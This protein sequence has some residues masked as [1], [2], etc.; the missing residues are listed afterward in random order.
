MLFLL[1]ESKSLNINTSVINRLH[2]ETVE[3][4]PVDIGVDFLASNTING[5][6]F[7]L[8]MVAWLVNIYGV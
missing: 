3:G 8:L 5:E 2:S 1:L 4:M 6:L 7:K